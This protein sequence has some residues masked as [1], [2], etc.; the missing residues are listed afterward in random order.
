MILGRVWIFYERKCRSMHEMLQLLLEKESFGSLLTKVANFTLY[1]YI[2][3]FTWLYYI[4]WFVN[5]LTFLC[6]NYYF[7][8]EQ[9]Y[10]KRKGKK[11]NNKN[12]KTKQ[13]K[14]QNKKKKQ[15]KTYTKT[16]NKKK[17]RNRNVIINSSKFSINQ[18]QW[19]KVN[20]KPSFLSK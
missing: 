8:A 11:N 14:K 10:H 15:Q 9:P 18:T 6:L 17:K 1:Y 3:L 2:Y 19:W 5:F 16:K 4:L 7:L 20:Y 12:K 13:N